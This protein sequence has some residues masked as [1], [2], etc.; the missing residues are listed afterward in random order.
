MKAALYIRVSTSDQHVENQLPMIQKYCADR[1]WQIVI[2]CKDTESGVSSTR[3]GRND[4][5]QLAEHKLFDVV[6]VWKLDRWSRSMLDT[7]QTINQLDSFGVRF[8]SV[9]EELDT[10]TASGELLFN[11][12]ASV[13]TFERSI[14]KERIKAGLAR[15]KAQGIK[16]GQ[17][18]K[19]PPHVAQQIVD[20]RLNGE[21]VRQVAKSL[22]L[23][24]GAVEAAMNRYYQ[25]AQ[26]SSH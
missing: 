2:T 24:R 13:A 25:S 16:L 10:K 4:L 8:V 17:P 22:K 14:L 12:L 15:A 6:V 7:Q 20:R 23:S 9:T 3:K 18:I 19:T 21:S 1:G 26:S 5:L 11:V